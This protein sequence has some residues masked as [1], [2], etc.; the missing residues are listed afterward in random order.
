MGVNSLESRLFGQLPQTVHTS[1]QPKHLILFDETDRKSFGW[2]LYPYIV[3]ANHS[4][5]E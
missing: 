2:I 4:I 3:S 1:S 5:Q